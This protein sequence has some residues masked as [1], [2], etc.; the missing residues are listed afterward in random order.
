MTA[1]SHFRWLLLPFSACYGIGVWIRN[2]FFN[3]EILPSE[4]FDI[5]VLSVGNITVGG[6]GKT[7]MALSSCGIAY[8]FR[9]IRAST[10]G[11]VELG[12]YPNVAD[13]KSVV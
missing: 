7:P 9:Y 13:R 2:I 12:L 10:E 5:P 3:L 8:V 11:A 4:R 1:N 6:T